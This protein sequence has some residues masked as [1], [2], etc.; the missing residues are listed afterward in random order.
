[1]AQFKTVMSNVLD[2]LEQLDK[3]FEKATSDIQTLKQQTEKKMTEAFTAFQVDGKRKIDSLDATIQ[4]RLNEFGNR[5]TSLEQRID[6]KFEDFR[7]KFVTPIEKKLSEAEVK[8]SK[9]E[10]TVSSIEEEIKKITKELGIKET[11]E[12][13]A[14]QATQATQATKQESMSRL[15]ILEQKIAKID[16]VR[17]AAG[18]LIIKTAEDITNA[19]ENL[20]KE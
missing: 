13:N 6:S 18:T 8:L 11:T 5:I 2:Q 4:S 19:G 14:A 10:K 1:M 3:E 15:A 9:I 16:S 17:K 7:T 12:N 20:R